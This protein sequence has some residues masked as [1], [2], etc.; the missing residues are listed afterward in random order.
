MDELTENEMKNPMTPEE[1]K[2]AIDDNVDGCDM[3]IY[4]F[5]KGNK[6][7]DRSPACAGRDL[8]FDQFAYRRKPEL[9]ER[10]VK[11]KPSGEQYSYMSYQLAKEFGPE[12]AQIVRLVEDPTW[13]EP[14]P[15]ETNITPLTGEENELIEESLDRVLQAK[16]EKNPWRPIVK[17]E[18][19]ECSPSK[20]IELKFDNVYT[21]R[22]TA[23]NIN[24]YPVTARA[25][26]YAEDE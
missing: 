24:Q 3:Q 1:M 19:P 7:I 21:Q 23:E 2:Q 20:L 22:L 5:R 15:E 17:G 12:D 13:V 16:K 25:W 10:F 6:W 9:V 8:D 4:R 26:R 11:I 14:E 18:W